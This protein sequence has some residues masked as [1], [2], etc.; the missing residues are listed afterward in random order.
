MQK[1]IMHIFCVDIGII[2]R[3]LTF[4]WGCILLIFML[5]LQAAYGAQISYTY[6]SLSRLTQATYADGTVI[7]YSYDAAGNRLSQNITQVA[8][9]ITVQPQPQ[10]AS[11]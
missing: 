8:P 1:M 2:P 4:Q 6:D 5:S 9:N 3:R 10:T 7:A 11:P